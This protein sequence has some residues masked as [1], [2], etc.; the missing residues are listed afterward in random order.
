M[1]DRIPLYFTL[2]RVKHHQ[3][4]VGS[5]GDRDDLSSSAFALRGTFDNTRQIEQLYFGAFVMNNA[6]HACQCGKLVGGDHTLGARHRAQQCR[7]AHRW[8]AYESHAGIA[9]FHHIE[10][11]ALGARFSLG[12]KQLSSILG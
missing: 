9:R 4:H 6:R 3:H 10:A 7:L 8:K 1:V 12:L 2:G 5:A 11:F